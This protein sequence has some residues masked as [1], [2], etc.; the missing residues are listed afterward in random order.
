MKEL[1]SI[2][3]AA[4]KNVYWNRTQNEFEVDNTSSFRNIVYK[5]VKILNNFQITGQS[6]CSIPPWRALTIN[7]KQFPRIYLNQPVVKL[8][9]M[10]SWL[11]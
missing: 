9:S 5:K 4:K 2:T 1:V 8:W 11:F 6:L 3:G 7:Q 10:N